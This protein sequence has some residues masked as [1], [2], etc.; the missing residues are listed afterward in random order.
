MNWPEWLREFTQPSTITEAEAARIQDEAAAQ[1]S[2]VWISAR[3]VPSLPE[4]PQPP[5]LVTEPEAVP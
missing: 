1:G 4:P 3:V 5:C 2:E